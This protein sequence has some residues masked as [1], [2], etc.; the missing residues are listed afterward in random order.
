MST[1]RVAVEWTMIRLDLSY[2]LRLSAQLARVRFLKVDA[3]ISDT[4]SALEEARTWLTHFGQVEMFHSAGIAHCQSPAS[5]S[6]EP[7]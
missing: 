3:N 4:R 1:E 6:F 5:S 2:F 7:Y